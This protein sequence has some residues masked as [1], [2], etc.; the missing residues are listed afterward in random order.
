MTLTL[1]LRGA[2]RRSNLG[3]ASLGQGGSKVVSN[4]AFTTDCFFFRTD[5]RFRG[6]DVVDLDDAVVAQ[7]FDFVRGD[8]AELAQKR[9]GMLAE[10]WRAGH[11]G[12]RVRQFDRAADSL[13]GAARRVI[14]IEDHVAGLQVRIGEHLA[15]VLAGAARNT[16]LTQYTH[17]LVLAAPTRP[18]LDYRIQR[19]AVFPAHLRRIETRI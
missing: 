7:S 1:S 16:R 17:D 14:D 13:V 3:A 4:A 5:L 19:F 6:N 12:R 18:F 15:G 2:Q 9:V 8:A 10:Q 11:L